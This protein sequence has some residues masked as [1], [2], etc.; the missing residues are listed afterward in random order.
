MASLLFK[1][2]KRTEGQCSLSRQCGLE[3]LQ[4]GSHTETHTLCHP[5]IKSPRPPLLYTIFAL[6]H[7]QSGTRAGVRLNANSVKVSLRQAE[8]SDLPMHLPSPSPAETK[9][10]KHK[11]LSKPS[12][13]TVTITQN[14]PWV[15]SRATSEQSMFVCSATR[16][17]RTIHQWQIST[18]Y[19]WRLLWDL[20]QT[21]PLEFPYAQETDC[22]NKPWNRSQGREWRWLQ[23]KLHFVI[24]LRS[25][26]S[27]NNNIAS[28]KIK[29]II[30]S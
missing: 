18:N 8:E 29:G 21:S 6:A 27:W 22:T 26:N 10:S 30:Y 15:T 1:Q 14:A 2:R 17:H 19:T 7:A 24:S 28:E 11:H 5:V 20:I 4:P 3:K 23:Q 9:G 25:W 16:V 13:N 12:H